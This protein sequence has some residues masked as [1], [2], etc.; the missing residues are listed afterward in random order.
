MKSKIIDIVAQ[1]RINILAGLAEEA[2]ISNIPQSFALAKRYIGIARKI[3]SH[4]KVKIPKRI[5]DRICKSCNNFLVP[6]VN[7]RVRKASV[8]DCIVYKCSC[9]EEKRVFPKS[10]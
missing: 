10:R 1:E 4:Y 2:E 8:P 3:S 5:S 9:G 6:G 7:C